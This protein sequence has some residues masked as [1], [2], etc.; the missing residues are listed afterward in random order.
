MEMKYKITQ[1]MNIAQL[2]WYDMFRE[3]LSRPKLSR[4]LQG[5]SRPIKSWS[6]GIE[7]K[8][9]GR[10]LDEEQHFQVFKLFESLQVISNR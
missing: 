9:Q 3:I 4:S 5:R 2:K 1:D 7:E 10:G 8:T 6:E